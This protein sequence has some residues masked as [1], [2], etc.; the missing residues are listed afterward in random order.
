MLHTSSASIDWEIVWRQS[1]YDKGESADYANIPLSEA[2]YLRFIQEILEGEKVSPRAFEEPKYFEGCLPVEVMAERGIQTLAYGPLKPVGLTDPRTGT[3][4]YAVAQLRME[5][6]EG[7]AWNMV[8][9]QTRL[10]YPEQR[11]IF[12]GLPGLKNA[13]FLRLGSIHRNTY[14][15]A[16]SVL[17]D[18]LRCLA[19]P[20]LYFAGQITGVEGYVESTACG[21]LVAWHILSHLKDQTLV[22]PPP[23]TAFGSMYRHLR[24]DGMYSDYVP[25]NLNWSLF[26]PIEKR[27]REKKHERRARMAVRAQSDFKDWWRSQKEH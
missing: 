3:R 19:R 18:E 17:S 25:S 14:I 26:S 9:F 1:R 23:T 10:K 16:P 27:R 20:D 11:R 2:E 7:S 12:K 8:G 4:P 6:K 5:N 24:H 21:L 15:H 22:L 13:E